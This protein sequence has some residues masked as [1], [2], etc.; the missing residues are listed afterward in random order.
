M[1]GTGFVV[2]PSA[3]VLHYA[4]HRLASVFAPSQ[5]NKEMVRRCV[6]CT[7]AQQ[8]VCTQTTK[9]YWHTN[10]ERVRKECGV[11]LPF[12]ADVSLNCVLA[13]NTTACQAFGGNTDP[14]YFA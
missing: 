5:R 11:P 10:P 8:R 13:H 9:L 14:E 4:H 7:A 3:F 12:V 6:L 2:H 1:L